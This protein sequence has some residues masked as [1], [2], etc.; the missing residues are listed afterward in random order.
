MM[1]NVNERLNQYVE[2]VNEL[3]EKNWKLSGY[4]FPATAPTAQV[5]M[6]KRFAKIVTGHFNQESTGK[7]VHTFIDMTNGDI[8]KAASYKAPAKNGKRGNIFADDC[9]QSCITHHGAA[10][11]Y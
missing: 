10:Y 11:R 3:N 7:G 1:T 6:G 4:T 8:L 2:L 5:E 9:G